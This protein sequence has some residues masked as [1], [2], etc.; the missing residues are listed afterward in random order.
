MGVPYWLVGHQLVCRALPYCKARVP[1]LVVTQVNAFKFHWS[2]QRINV[3]RD[4]VV[5]FVGTG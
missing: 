3:S 1:G 2:V 5:T 4:C